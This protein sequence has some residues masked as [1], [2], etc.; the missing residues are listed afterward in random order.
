MKSHT[1]CLDCECRLDLIEDDPVGI[2]L[3]ITL[4]VQHH[5]LECSEVRQRDLSVFRAVVISIDEGI[6]VEVVLT[7]ISNSVSY[8]NHMAEQKSQGQIFSFYG[9]VQ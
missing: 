5:R 6:V 4:R 2:N 8:D 3:S 9:H 7:H 1:K